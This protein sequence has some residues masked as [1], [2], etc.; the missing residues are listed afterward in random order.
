MP[1]AESPSAKKDKIDSAIQRLGVSPGSGI[2]K[3]QKKLSHKQRKRKEAGMEKAEAVLEK[4]SKKVEGGLQRYDKVQERRVWTPLSV[5]G[6][7]N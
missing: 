6:A 4:L 2:K 5:F 7:L 1:R 3:K